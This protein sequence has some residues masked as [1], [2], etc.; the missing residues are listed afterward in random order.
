MGV[1]QQSKGSN[2][3]DAVL[4]FMATHGLRAVDL[5][6]AELRLSGTNWEFVIAAGFLEPRAVRRS[7]SSANDE[8]DRENIGLPRTR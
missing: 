1:V 7:G 3:I 2:G 4:E 5:I 8:N 6:A